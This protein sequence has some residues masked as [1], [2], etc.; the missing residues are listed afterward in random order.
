MADNEI[1]VIEHNSSILTQ[2]SSQAPDD[3]TFLAHWKEF[4]PMFIGSG[5]PSRDT[6]K[7]YYSAIEQFLD[8]CF[9]HNYHPMNIHDYQMRLFLNWLY[10]RDY[11]K[12]T[13]ALKIIAVRNFYG[14]AHKLHVIESNPVMDINVPQG[15][16]DELIRFFTPNQ[17]YEIV[18]AFNE[19]VDLFQ[20][21]RNLSML[22]LMGVEGLRNIE[23]HRI[24]REDI[25]WDTGTIV[26]R[27]KGH[28][29]IIYPC[30]D[31]L[32]RIKTYLSLCPEETL[33]KRDNLT[34]LFLSKSHRNQWGR[35][36]RNGLRFVMNKALEQTGYKKEG[37]SCHVFR[38]STATNLYAATKDLRLVQETLGHRNPQVTAK[39]AH[40]QE[41]MTKRRTAA[42]VP[43]PAGKK[44]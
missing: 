7:T 44:S 11:K 29:R 13:I 34:P 27:G 39:Y 30:E 42:I 23:I 31:T 24:N 38:H 18:E 14:A 43:T 26:V 32:T 41:R 25:D 15:S 40:L 5:K 28:N 1:V 33:I 2:P 37:I 10:N 17:L 35:I 6:I 8:W 20:R 22:Y 16:D 3:V 12:E 21:E 19:E 36:S 9:E 4:L